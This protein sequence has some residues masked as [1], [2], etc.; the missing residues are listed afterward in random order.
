ML[1]LTENRVYTRFTYDS[2]S[3]F[4]NN[5]ETTRRTIL[6]FQE[7]VPV[8]YS[9]NTFSPKTNM[10]EPKYLYGDAPSRPPKAIWD[11]HVLDSTDDEGTHTTATMSTHQTRRSRNTEM[12]DA[13]KQRVQLW[14]SYR[15]AR[16]ITGS[17]IKA[18]DLK[19][20]TILQ[21][22]R[23]VAEMKL[24]LIQLNQQVKSLEAASTTDEESKSRNVNEDFENLKTLQ[25]EFKKMIKIAESSVESAREKWKEAPRE[26]RNEL[27]KLLK[28]I[29]VK[30][31]KTSN[32][33]KQ[34]ITSL[35][36]SILQAHP[37]ADL[38]AIQRK[39]KKQQEVHKIQ[40][41]TVQ[42]KHL[43]QIMDL[44]GQLEIYKEQV[45]KQNQEIISWH[46]RYHELDD[47]AVTP[48][49]AHDVLAAINSITED[50][51]LD[52]Q[53][54]VQGQV[55]GILERMSQMY[56]RQTADESQLQ[57][58]LEAAK[59][60]EKNTKE[61]F[62][63]L[64]C[65]EILLEDE[66]AV[67]V[68]DWRGALADQ[69]MQC[70]RQ[71]E[72]IMSREERRLLEMEYLEMRLTDMAYVAVEIEGLQKEIDES[73]K[74]HSRKVKK[75]YDHGDYCAH[76][77]SKIKRKMEEVMTKQKDSLKHLAKSSSK[78]SKWISLQDKINDIDRIHKLEQDLAQR[79]RELDQAKKDISKQQGKIDLLE[80]KLKIFEAS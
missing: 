69:K 43:Q 12:T 75:A 26:T 67:P 6:G 33:I 24:E 76:S 41:Q 20:K 65:E 23:V 71:I 54:R 53:M 62:K 47:L 19:S 31:Q 34:E 52:D 22:I 55:V 1:M 80:H 37:K 13:I 8:I 39:L 4:Q 63:D 11:P 5:R 73:K 27:E 9:I 44:S 18:F 49:Q 66:T 59:R 2:R 46:D 70:K 78:D 60:K 7:N 77:I 14:D 29:L 16:I 56:T 3:H 51:S 57:A 74:E 10:T 48:A 28:T 30:V 64:K 50:S 45:V 25:V 35:R 79:D 32:E 38:A 68:E 40:M 58:T 15:L 61:A 17:P 21:A 36:R 72:D 42:H